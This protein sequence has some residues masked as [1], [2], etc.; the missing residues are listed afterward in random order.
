MNSVFLVARRNVNNE[1][2]CYM[3]AKF[4]N[5]IVALLELTLVPGSPTAKVIEFFYDPA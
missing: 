3:S 4:I 1:N 2:L 5:N